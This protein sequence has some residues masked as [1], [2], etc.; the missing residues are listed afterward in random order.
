MRVRILS[1]CAAVL[2][3]SAITGCATDD[4]D[5]GGTAPATVA[6]VDH[7]YGTT[8]VDGTPDRIVATSSQWVDA[9]L[10]F[11]VQPVG[12][13]SAGTMGDDRGLYPWQQAVSADAVELDAGNIAAGQ[14][15]LPTEEIAALEPDLILGNWQ[16]TDRSAYDTLAAVAPTVAPL[17]GAV[18]PWDDQIR[19]LGVLLGREDDADRIVADRNAEIDEYALPGL[20]GRTAVLS[21]FLFGPQ[22][23]VLVA[24]PGDGAATVFE[25]IGMTLPPSLVEEAGVSMGR[26][27]LSPERVDALV[28]D[29][30]IILPN[31]GT[32]AD[33]MALP[34]FDQL[35]AVRS[36]ALAVLDYP[37]VV[38]FNTPSA[39]S[40]LYGLDAI[41]PQL[42]AVAAA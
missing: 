27:T 14:G 13:I 34:G 31:G 21:Q 12:Y 8:T 38:A 15:P 39:A 11:D 37:T 18:D 1:L 9:L 6:A 28:A 17:S 10:E 26:L 40:A 24:D 35:P 5:T 20:D 36:G 30:L 32:E 3:G 4:G 41:R 23:F 29:L 33:L 25:Q 19:A 16:I 42:E 2:V 22:Q 7:L